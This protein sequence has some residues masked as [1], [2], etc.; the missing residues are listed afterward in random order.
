MIDRAGVFMIQRK[1]LGLNFGGKLQKIFSFFVTLLVLSNCG[2]H[3]AS[4]DCSGS[5][6]MGCGSMIGVHKAIKNDEFPK[7]SDNDQISSSKEN[8]KITVNSH[9]GEAFTTN[10]N[11]HQIYRTQDKIMRV[12]FNGYFDSQN[13]FH[14][15]QYI[16]TIISPAQW[17]V[18]K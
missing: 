6:G 1:N 8:N 14:D 18:T 4:F 9:I 16:Y 15:S 3:K 2:V 12:W 10:N 11:G 17:V 7:D 5:K 13:N